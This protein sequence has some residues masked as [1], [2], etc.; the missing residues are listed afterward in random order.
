[1]NYIDE[2]SET[3][4]MIIDMDIDGINEIDMAIVDIDEAAK[5]TKRLDDSATG[6]MVFLIIL[7]IFGIWIAF[8]VLNF[9]YANFDYIV[10]GC[11]GLVVIAVLLSEVKSRVCGA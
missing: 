1:M 2:V 9:I 10:T 7:G 6:L 11:F 4:D 8:K 5:E 3:V